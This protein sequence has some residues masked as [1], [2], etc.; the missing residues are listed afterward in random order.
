MRWWDLCI[1]V[2]FWFFCKWVERVL[3][4]KSLSSLPNL[5][6]GKIETTFSKGGEKENA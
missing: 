6:K 3:F 5:I 4:I 1:A 2:F